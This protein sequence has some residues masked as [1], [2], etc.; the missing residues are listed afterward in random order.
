MIL[1]SSVLHTQA[2]SSTKQYNP[3]A[4]QLV[5]GKANVFPV[6]DVKLLDGPFKESQDAEARYLLSLEPNRLLAPFRIASGLKSKDSP[7]P[8]WE[9]TPHPGV[10]LSFYLSGMSRLYAA[11]GNNEYLSRINYILD[12]LQECQKQN[13]G[14]LL[15][16]RG[17]VQIFEKL[18][19]GFYSGFNDWNNGHG[20]PYY[21]MEKLF[22]GLLDTY[23]ITGSDK[24]LDIAV[25]LADWLA[26]HMA[27]INDEELEK[28]MQVEYG[29]M[30]WVLADM[31]AITGNQKY[32]AMSKRWQDKDV[33]VPLCN[34][35]DV[36]TDKHANTQFPKMS[37]LAA[38]YLYAGDPADLK[39]AFLFWESVVNHRSYATGGNGESEFFAAKD[40][41]SH[42]LTLFTEENCNEYNML[43]LTALL[44]QIEP[45]VEYADYMERVLF[46]HILSAQNREDGRICYFLP[47]I[48]GAHRDYLSLFES[49]VCCVCSG[50]DCYTRHSEYIYAHNDSSV[51]VN[52]FVASELN[53]KEK[54]VRIKQVTDF[55]FNDVS[56]I[57]FECTEPVELC[58]MIRNPY[59]LAQP[60]VLKV[61]GVEQKTIHD[62]GYVVIKRLWHTGDVVELKLPMGIR[63]ESMQDDAN[64]IAF[65]CGPIL[66]AGGFGKEEGESLMK[67]N[68][69]P[70]IVPGDKPVG[71]WL[72]PAKSPLHYKTTVVRPNDVNVM[73]L[74]KI[75]GNYA[76]Y[77]QKM[78]EE[79]WQLRKV[80]KDEERKR[81]E[82]LDQITIDKV[83]VG[84]KESEQN[85]G[86][87]G[88]SEVGKGTMGQLE[89]VVWRKPAGLGGFGYK[90]RIN[91]NIP[92]ALHCKYMGR[93][94]YEE[95][96][97]NIKIDTTTIKELKR[98]KDDSYPVMP[99]E[100]VYAIPVE[101]TK[102]GE[103]KDVFFDGTKM[104]RLIEMRIIKRERTVNDKID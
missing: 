91:G 48:P 32:L 19:E 62:S 35:I 9:I 24:A 27:R 49:F 89:D 85:H 103:L 76:V 64:K 94:A 53:W 38:R 93:A 102:N 100:A 66:L 69:P 101:L 54:G 72:S 97:C 8:G 68:E 61:N 58:L 11:T 77:W 13:N 4:K 23:R 20:V 45:R 17:G 95:W 18:E 7:Y 26:G 6:G 88:N 96:D 83:I 33:I 10:A 41:L 14:Y 43:R 73:P 37:G 65:F 50:M 47:L 56:V 79:Q 31:Y 99:F 90:M 59:W 75:K 51:Y 28:I 39:G 44:Y 36:L 67:R 81:A 87:Y 52:L 57:K 82:L 40:S 71:Q 74:F 16:L 70:A 60:M 5:F 55:P 86:L 34:G 104:P 78:S 21:S 42:K 3:K 46:D 80:Q 92:L 2:D 25:K 1:I 15:G 29:G 30:N 22:S 84:D 63:A 12:N 98:A